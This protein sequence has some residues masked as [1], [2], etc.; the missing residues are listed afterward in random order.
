MY[1]TKTDRANF[2]LFQI[3]YLVGIAILFMSCSENSNNNNSDLL[4][5]SVTQTSLLKDTILSIEKNLELKHQAI[6]SIDISKFKDIRDYEKYMYPPILKYLKKDYPELEEQEMIVF[7]FEQIKK[8]RVERKALFKN[9]QYKI[10]DP[11]KIFTLN[12]I[13]FSK[14]NY[15]T[16]NITDTTKKISSI[17]L[18]ISKNSGKKWQFLVHDNDVETNADLKGILEQEFTPEETSQIILK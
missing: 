15:S 2:R 17:I 4:R 9:L 11:V 8:M 16:I 14:V 12:N 1:K 7:L 10:I 5:T 18:G 3:I 13:L 6:S